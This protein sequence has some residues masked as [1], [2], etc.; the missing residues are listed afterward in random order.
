M[1]SGER[2]PEV[3]LQLGEFVVPPG[4]RLLLSVAE[5]SDLLGLSRAFFYTLLAAG[6]VPS[7][8]VGRRRLI[9]WVDLVGFVES[10]GEAT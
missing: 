8:K 6:R 3:I 4:G 2:Q 1:T 9:R 10:L 7:V 5:A